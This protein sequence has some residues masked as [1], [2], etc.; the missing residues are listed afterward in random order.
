MK[1]SLLA[2]LY[3]CLLISSK[4]LEQETM[5]IPLQTV[6]VKGVPKYKYLLN[7]DPDIEK[8]SD[9]NFVMKA[10]GQSFFNV[11]RLFLAPIKVGSNNQP[12]TLLLDTGSPLL[13]VPK[14]GSQDSY[15]TITHHYNPSTST[16]S[17]N[18]LSPFSIRY[19]TGSCSGYYYIDKLTYVGNQ[20][21]SCVF[22]VADQT[23]LS[24]NSC[25]GIIGLSKNYQQDSLSFIHNIKTAKITNNLAFSLKFNIQNNQIVGKMILGKDAD[26]SKSNTATC[27]LTTIP[28]LTNNIFWACMVTS[29]G[30]KTSTAHQ[31]FTLAQAAIFD[32]GTNNIML[33][34]SM[35][36]QVVNRLK[37][38]Y[39]GYMVSGNAYR[40]VCEITSNLPDFTLNIN[41]YEY[42]LPK[43]IMYFT[44]QGKAMANVLFSN[45][46]PFPI[47]GSQFFVAFHTLFDH[48]SNHMTFYPSHGTYKKA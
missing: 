5:E 47:I 23:A 20:K 10:E 12:F 36:S 30:I 19:G 24:I 43:D 1:K 25:D 17:K 32:T 45:S 31:T 18:T 41:G 22:G 35:F 40:I 15:P 6:P 39:C 46:L 34:L 37:K 28:N 16:T 44:Y 2:W 21:F 7:E 42:T 27:P 38:F 11:N 14:V 33:P 4:A 13:W 26:F 8:Y 48:D 9:T 29:F 3:I